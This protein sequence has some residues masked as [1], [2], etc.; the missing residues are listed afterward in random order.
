M[1]RYGTAREHTKTKPHVGRQ[2]A[3]GEGS[4]KGVKWT[5]FDSLPKSQETPLAFPNA[6]STSSQSKL[7]AGT[8]HPVL[9][10]L[11]ARMQPPAPPPWCTQAFLLM[12]K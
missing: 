8:Q 5:L 11:W 3:V 4:I 9:V 1:A 2:A 10:L 12:S 7:Q 6:K